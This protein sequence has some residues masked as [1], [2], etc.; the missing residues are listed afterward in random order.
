MARHVFSGWRE[1]LAKACLRYRLKK[2]MKELRKV[3]EAKQKK[4]EGLAIRQRIQ[5]SVERI[6][7]GHSD[8]DRRKAKEKYHARQKRWEKVTGFK[9]GP[10]WEEHDYG[11]WDFGLAGPNGEREVNTL[12]LMD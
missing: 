2:R 12:D 9:Y 3:R 6:V 7:K 10:A 8:E 5:R 11:N 1:K 4:E